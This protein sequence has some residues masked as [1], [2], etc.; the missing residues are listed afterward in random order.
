LMDEGG[1][2]L[3][4]TGDLATLRYDFLRRSPLFDRVFAD[5]VLCGLFRM[6]RVFGGPHARAVAACFEHV[7]PKYHREYAR[8]FGGAE[9]FSQPFTTLSFSRSLLDRP[10]LHRHGELSAVLRLQAEREISRISRGLDEAERV[11][12]YLL[13]QRPSRL[14]DVKTA[15]RDMGISARSMRR[16]L[17]RKGVSYRALVQSVRETLA[18]RML[19]D[20][21]TTIQEVAY[22]L[23]FSDS[24]AF[25]RAF[26][27]WKGA[28]P[29]TFQKFPTPATGIP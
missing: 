2:V 22:A 14:P 12:Q 26:K 16:M 23:G 8:V 11:R 28:T 1:L 21:N 6:M 29:G 27:R 7:R 10:Q 15:A 19:S 24:T 5:F 25:H 13:V 3:R 18:A 17:A 20:K 4:E 9:R